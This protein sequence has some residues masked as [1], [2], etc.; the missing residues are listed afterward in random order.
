M[1]LRYGIALAAILT[2]LSAPAWAEPQSAY[3]GIG[4]GAVFLPD[5]KAFS[6][7]KFSSDTGWVGAGTVGLR[8]KDGWRMELEGALREND[9]KLAAF[10]GKI[11]SW[12]ITVN[13][14]RDLDM[15]WPVIPYIGAGLG[16]MRVNYDINVPNSERQDTGF[17]WQLIG[18]ITYPISKKLELFAD[19]RYFDSF[20]VKVTFAGIEPDD[21]YHGHELMAGLRWTFWSEEPAPV[22]AP[23]PAPVVQPKDYVIY[24]EFDKSN[25]TKAAG[26]VLDELKSTSGGSA[27]SVV[28]HTDTS[29]SAGYNQKLSER[30]AN[31][32]ATALESRSVKV[33]SVTG[34]GFTEPA[35]NTGPGV[36]EPL[37][38]RAVI[39]LEG[40]AAPT[41]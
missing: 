11:K 19:Y 20:S 16:T 41:H 7:L 22:A 4:A 3:L 35:V 15:G 2:G 32:T 39:K 8:W 38:R 26:A 17:M 23:A 18:G 27:V 24:F 9:S 33:N 1:Q 21:S 31:N 10:S 30:R 13:G 5:Q 40:P 14:L 29:G 6:G 36:K 25:V 37:N 28:G 34:R 12:N